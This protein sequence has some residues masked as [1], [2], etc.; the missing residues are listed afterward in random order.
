MFNLFNNDYD[1]EFI[2]KIKGLIKLNEEGNPKKILIKK[3]IFN[4]DCYTIINTLFHYA[5]MI[6]LGCEE[7]PTRKDFNDWANK[8]YIET[9][10]GGNIDND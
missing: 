7:N 9:V 8:V 10:S 1:D 6:Y 2:I 4:G 3:E 5:A